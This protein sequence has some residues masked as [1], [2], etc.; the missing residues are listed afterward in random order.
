MD[1]TN[2]KIHVRGTLSRVDGD[3]VVTD[4]KT[5]SK[6][7]TD[8]NAGTPPRTR[9]LHGSPQQTRCER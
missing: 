5:E 8:A 9:A 7:R 2:K 4:T 1:L 3:L 6:N